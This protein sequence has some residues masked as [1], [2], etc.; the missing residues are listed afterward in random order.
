M[1]ENM[2][3]LV[4]VYYQINKFYQF[5]RRY[6]KSKNNDQLQGKDIDK[7]VAKDERNHVIT[8]EDM[9]LT[10]NYKGDDLNPLD[11]AVPCGLIAKSFFRDS[12]IEINQ[13]DIIWEVDKKIKFDNLTE[14]K[15]KKQ[16][17][18]LTDEHFIV[19]MRLFHSP[20][21]LD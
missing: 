12:E 4:M 9:S 3:L 5:H 13:N 2:D 20:P 19:W 1:K 6:V 16:W 10:K 8:N 21:R 7:K 15:K 14:D 17:I 18:N 11:V